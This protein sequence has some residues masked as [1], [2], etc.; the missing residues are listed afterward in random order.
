[1]H[2]LIS[3]SSGMRLQRSHTDNDGPMRPVEKKKKKRAKK[4]TFGIQQYFHEIWKRLEDCFENNFEDFV[5]DEWKW[6]QRR[7]IRGSGISRLEEWLKKGI[8]DTLY[9]RRILR[10]GKR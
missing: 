6:E 7:R 3:G 4:S 9:A 5:L 8:H 2:L 1:M 10:K